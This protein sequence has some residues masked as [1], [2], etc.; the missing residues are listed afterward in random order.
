M[1]EMASLILNSS[2][3]PETNGHH[4]LCR[5]RIEALSRKDHHP[6]GGLFSDRLHCVVETGS[7]HQHGLNFFRHHSRTIRAL[8]EEATET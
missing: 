5:F 4:S 2:L 6:G 3:A 7:V 1:S 8:L